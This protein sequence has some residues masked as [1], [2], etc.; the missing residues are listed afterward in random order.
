MSRSRGC[1]D[2]NPPSQCYT[3]EALR[4]RFNSFSRGVLFLTCVAMSVIF[5]NSPYL[6]LRRLRP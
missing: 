5:L 1:F 6:P 3:S 4:L 2:G